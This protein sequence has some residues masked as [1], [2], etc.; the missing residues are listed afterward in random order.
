VIVYL[1]YRCLKEHGLPSINIKTTGGAHG[2]AELTS[3]LPDS[4]IRGAT[5]ESFLNE[6][7]REKHIRFTTK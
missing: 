3:L 5:I 7:T 2:E 4:T 6:I 1:V